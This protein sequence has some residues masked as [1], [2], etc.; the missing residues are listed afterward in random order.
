MVIKT[1]AD[2]AMWQTMSLQGPVKVLLFLQRIKVSYTHN[3][4]FFSSFWYFHGYSLL[5]ISIRLNDNNGNNII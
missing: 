4:Q 3:E 5:N 2:T 1:L